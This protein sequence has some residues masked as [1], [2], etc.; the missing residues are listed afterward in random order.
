MQAGASQNHEHHSW[1]LFATPV[2]RTVKVMNAT[3]ANRATATESRERCAQV[4]SASA[5]TDVT[6][7]CQVTVV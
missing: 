1:Y 3:E 6:E 5:T 4:H 7:V 2:K